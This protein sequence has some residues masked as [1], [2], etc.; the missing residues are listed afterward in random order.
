M[1][2][3]TEVQNGLTKSKNGRR[4]KRRTKRNGTTAAA[5][6]PARRNGTTKAGA[7]AW[8]KRNGMVV[9]TKTVANGKRK[10][11][12]RKKRNGTVSA[13]VSRS[14]NGI[15]GNSKHDVRQVVGLLGGMASTK[16]IG[17]IL[18][19]FASPYIAQLGIGNY[20]G[21]ISE[22]AV[23]LLLVPM[24]AKK[25]GNQNDA[26]NARL[27]GLA[28]VGLSLIDQVGGGTF[29]S[30][31]NPFNSSP[32]VMANGVAAVAPAQVAALV[33]NTSATAS[34]KAAVTG[35]MRALAAGRP[36]TNMA[37]GPR[38]SVSRLYD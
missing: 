8:A 19:N 11:H 21:I 10:H 7:K 4:R 6:A 12:R 24:I 29:L 38:A 17:N 32:I 31:L 16:I 15:L 26:Q 1:S 13:G 33:A 3:W 9:M 35:A 37:S 36:V 25:V 27:G 14:R 18:S 20:V 30:G 2:K 34:E 22:G 5:K 23:A 28:T